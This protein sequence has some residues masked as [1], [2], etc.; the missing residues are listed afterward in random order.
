MERFNSLNG[1][2]N[3]DGVFNFYF[4]NLVERS[5]QIENTDGIRYDLKMCLS[6]QPNSMIVLTAVFKNV[7]DLNFKMSISQ[8]VGVG[9]E[10]VSDRGLENCNYEIY[11]YEGD[12]F[13]FYCED[14][15]LTENGT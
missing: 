7:S 1:W 4:I 14:I 9:I 11:N 6:K 13:H 2:L 5:T 10:N 15:V 8:L 12:D 3:K